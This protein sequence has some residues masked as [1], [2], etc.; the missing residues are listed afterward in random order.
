MFESVRRAVCICSSDASSSK[1]THN[2]RKGEFVTA[3]FVRRY[4][5]GPKDAHA[6]LLVVHEP[7]DEVAEEIDLE[8]RAVV[9]S[10][11]SVLATETKAAREVLGLNP[12]EDN[13]IF[14]IVIRR[15]ENPCTLSVSGMVFSW[16]MEEEGVVHMHYV[17]PQV[18]LAPQVFRPGQM[19]D[20]RE[21]G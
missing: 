13:R 19:R 2:V 15:D 12:S 20:S 4:K 21:G 8:F 3:Y 17:Y 16:R 1:R 18:S 10:V 14:P 9:G 11:V 6:V 7:Q 5:Y